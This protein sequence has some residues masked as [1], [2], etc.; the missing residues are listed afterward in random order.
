M[1]P[2]RRAVLTLIAAGV[3]AIATACATARG[4]AAGQSV[5]RVVERLPVNG[6]TMEVEE[7]APPSTG[8]RRP[9]VVLLHGSGGLHFYNGGQIHRY[10]RRLAAR[11]FVAVV[12]H[13]FDATGSYDTD[14]AEERRNFEAWI[15][16][17]RTAVS[18]VRGLDDVDSARVG[19]FGHSLGGYLAVGV[20]AEDSRV[21]ALVEMSG[22]LEPFLAGRVQHLPPTLILHGTADDIV[23]RSEADTLAS[24]L[25]A[26]Q[27]PFTIKLYP[28]EGHVLGDSAESDALRRAAAFLEGRGN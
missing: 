23:P 15:G 22:G 16:A 1:R 12:V 17:V 28:G 2:E 25:S 24:Y 6:R 21:S 7:Y 27:L 14:A 18:W 26:H 9:A 4:S 13:Y 3:A 19:L 10:A 5:Q 8:E 20:A 11:G